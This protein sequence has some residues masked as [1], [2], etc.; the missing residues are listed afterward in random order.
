[1]AV[2]LHAFDLVVDLSVELAE[3]VKIVLGRLP[4]SSAIRLEEGGDHVAEG[5]RVCLEKAFLHLLVGDE[6]VIRVLLDEVVDGAGG[7]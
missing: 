6:D 3:A 1:M 2:V 5:V 4:I 7:S